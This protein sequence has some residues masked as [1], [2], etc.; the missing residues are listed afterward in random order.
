MVEFINEP[1]AHCSLNK[2]AQPPGAGFMCQQDAERSKHAAPQRNGK[3][4][5]IV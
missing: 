4:A 1:S 3:V 2:P 5:G